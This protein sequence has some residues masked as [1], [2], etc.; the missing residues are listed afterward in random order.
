MTQ[1]KKKFKIRIG[2]E[3]KGKNSTRL[4][5]HQSDETVVLITEISINK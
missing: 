1:K 3:E 4:V 2:E 5:A